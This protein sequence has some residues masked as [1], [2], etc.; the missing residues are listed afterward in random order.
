M[1][2]PEESSGEAHVFPRMKKNRHLASS[3]FTALGMGVLCVDCGCLTFFTEM[4]G[5]WRLLRLPK[6]RR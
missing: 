6:S 4:G 3:V 2:E 1:N 5:Q